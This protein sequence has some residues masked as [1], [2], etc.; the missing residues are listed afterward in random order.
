L[1]HDVPVAAVRFDGDADLA[2]RAHDAL[3]DAD[4]L[5]IAPSN[6]LVSIGPIR[7][8]PGVDDLLAERAPTPWR[9]RRSWVGLRSR[10]PPIGC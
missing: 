2:P 5:V 10:G 7:A 4:R 9:S 6:P 3:A 8:L 1:R